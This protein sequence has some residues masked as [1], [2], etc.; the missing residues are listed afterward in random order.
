M[1]RD[2]LNDIISSFLESN[3]KDYLH[4]DISSEEPITK[5]FLAWIAQESRSDQEI[6]SRLVE[7]DTKYETG[8]IDLFAKGSR[9][10]SELESLMKAALNDVTEQNL[11]DPHLNSLN[12][13]SDDVIREFL[14]KEEDTK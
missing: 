11:R 5:T 7:L 6:R 2:K 9:S 12:I 13:V 8:I 10:N 3:E 1:G 4:V 14:S